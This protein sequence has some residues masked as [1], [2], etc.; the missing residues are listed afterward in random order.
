M[1]Q[2]GSKAPDFTLEGSRDR[3]ITFSDRDS[4]FTVLVFYPKN[5]TPG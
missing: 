3:T 4:K 1:L 2:V 5:N